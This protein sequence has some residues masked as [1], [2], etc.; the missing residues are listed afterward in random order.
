MSIFMTVTSYA[1]V[2]EV[3]AGRVAMVAPASTRPAVSPGNSSS[4]ACWPRAR[5]PVDVPRLRHSAKRCVAA[6][7][8]RRA[9]PP[10]PRHGRRQHA[11]GEQPGLPPRAPRPGHSLRCASEPPRVLPWQIGSAW[12]PEIA[13][14][15]LDVGRRTAEVSTAGAPGAS[16]STYAPGR[17]TRAA[18]ARRNSENT[19]CRVTRL[20]RVDVGEVGELL[21]LP[22]RCAFATPSSVSTGSTAWR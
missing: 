10:R 4:K 3:R 19:E 12:L 16:S 13:N 2:L 22:A 11:S 18:A 17:S 21:G 1:E 15:A 6:R 20:H 14:R 5:K 9:P 7:K 8:A